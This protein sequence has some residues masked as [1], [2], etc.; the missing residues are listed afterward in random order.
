MVTCVHVLNHLWVSIDESNYRTI[1]F[2]QR[3]GRPGSER[4]EVC[5]ITALVVLPAAVDSLAQRFCR[6]AFP[7]TSSIR[8]HSLHQVSLASCNITLL[9]C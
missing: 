2:E 9:L 5:L 7:F 4:G 6:R 3:Y 8:Y 1:S